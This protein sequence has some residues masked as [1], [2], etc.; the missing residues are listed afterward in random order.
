M[1]A[2]LMPQV[3]HLRQRVKIEKV[4]TPSTV[5]TPYLERDPGLCFSISTF[6]IDKCE[7][8]QMAHI[9]MGLFQPKLQKHPST[10]HS[11]Q[12]RRFQF[13]WFSKFP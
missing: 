12:N 1:C 11:T 6:T 5:D 4:D 3:L 9:N 7:D 2:T 10:K 13:S 8:V